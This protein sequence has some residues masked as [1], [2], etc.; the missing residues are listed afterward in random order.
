[1]SSLLLRASRFAARHVAT[2]QISLCKGRGVLSIS[3]DDV[4][5]SACHIGASL[6]EEFE[7][8]GT[9]FVCGGLTNGFEQQQACHSLEDLMQLQEAG[10]EIACH[11]YSHLN[12]AQTSQAQLEMDLAKNQTFFKQHGISSSG[13]AFPFGAYTLRSKL[14]AK[15]QFAYARITEG[16]ANYASADLYALRAQSLYSTNNN[17][18]YLQHL[19]RQTAEQG[20]WL[21][22]YT[23]EVDDSPGPWGCKPE[24]LRQLLECAQQQG[25]QILPIRRAI[26]YFTS[27]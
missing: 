4:P 9:Y 8:C 23:H 21:I 12:C 10:H 5:A 7:A 20:G 27:R 16:G 19:I 26:S 24:Q 3:F 17:L 22:L 25:S 18:D 14:V 11:T 13:F 6:L 1:M 15:R 2:E